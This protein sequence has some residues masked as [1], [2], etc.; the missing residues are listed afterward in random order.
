VATNVSTIKGLERLAELLEG[1][2]PG[3]VLSADEV[4]E[5]HAWT[6]LL[7]HHLAAQKLQPG[8]YVNDKYHY[9]ASTG[10]IERYRNGTLVSSI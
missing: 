10:H 5:L 9:N 6:R 3:V 7:S 4:A 1:L 8:R 2:Q